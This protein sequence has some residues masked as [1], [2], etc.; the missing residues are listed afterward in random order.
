MSEERRRAILVVG[1]H[2]S[3]TS[4]AT[5]VL[6]LKGVPLPDRLVP[7]FHG[8]DL[9]HWEPEALPALH[10]AMLQS[11]GVDVNS[12]FGVDPAWFGSPEAGQFTDE[13]E[14]YLL[15]EVAVAPVVALKDPRMAL[16]VP[17]WLEAMRRLDVAPSFVIPFRP[18]AEVAASLR[19]RQLQVFPDAVW[20]EGR[21]ALVWLS[22]VLAAERDTRGH[23]RT[24]VAFDALLDDWRGE[25]RRMGAQLALD[26]PRS[27]EAAG[28]EIDAYLDRQ[29]KHQ[30]R[31][32]TA[33]THG[34]DWPARVMATLQRCVDDPDGEAAAFDLARDA[35]D[36]A[37]GLFR[38][39]VGALEGKIGS[40]PM[41]R[42]E[43]S[44][45]SPAITFPPNL[46]D[47][48]G[49]E[50]VPMLRRTLEQR[51]TLLT[52]ALAETRVLSCYVDEMQATGRAMADALRTLETAELVKARAERDDALRRSAERIDGLQI[53][54]ARLLSERDQLVARIDE[55]V[56]RQE[57]IE[58]ALA[59]ARSDL[60][61][62]RAEQELTPPLTHNA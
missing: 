8:N 45:A 30:N 46:P 51:G 62:V 23:P 42:T 43:F 26:W 40:V 35:L 18:A 58:A 56:R 9:G 34:E 13:V 38:G 6:N 22:Y 53:L 33:A 60:A 48:S 49:C 20:P 7:A 55:G 2:R 59:D 36:D 4:A 50:D 17:V 21:G 47:L 44:A 12:T 37:R 57:S 5:R 14:N 16:F 61:G 11:A 52:A 29:H 1:M 24:F 41:L 3:G 32:D 39:Y 31:G 27:D 15:G 28:S 10:D 19:E 54:V 25:T